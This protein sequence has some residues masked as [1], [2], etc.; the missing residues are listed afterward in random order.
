MCDREPLN[1]QKLLYADRVAEWF[2][3]DTAELFDR[4]MQGEEGASALDARNRLSC[5]LE[6]KNNTSVGMAEISAYLENGGYEAEKIAEFFEKCEAE[7]EQNSLASGYANFAWRKDYILYEFF[8][9]DDFGERIPCCGA[10]FRL[11]L[12]TCAKYSKYMSFILENDELER[13]PVLKEHL[14]TRNE[15]HW[16]SGV[17]NKQL[18]YSQDSE[19]CFFNVTEQLLEGLL[20]IADDLWAFTHYYE[21]DN[22][23]DP[24]FYRADGSVFFTSVTHEGEAEFSLREN[25]TIEAFVT[26]AEKV[27]CCRE[28]LP[29]SYY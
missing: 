18:R 3:T 11:L 26:D 29:E 16:L 23:E 28:E 22:P 15:H 19:V 24:T 10:D 5:Y 7:A 20:E 14:V 13:F 17:Y 1:E 25:E 6:Y 12:Q 21:F 9:H 2:M 27:Q 8:D 4:V